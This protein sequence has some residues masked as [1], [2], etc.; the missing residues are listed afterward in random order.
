MKKT[1]I[2]AA[3]LLAAI[4]LVFSA[5]KQPSDD[6]GDDS[7]DDTTANVISADI[8]AN[9]T[10]AT[11]VWTVTSTFTVSADLIIPAGTT[12]N[13]Q[14][15]TAMIVDTNGSVTASGTSGE[16]VVF[17]SAKTTKAAG[18]WNG[19]QV[20]S[21]SASFT[22]C[23]FSYADTALDLR[24]SANTVNS[25]TFSHNT[26]GL[27][28]SALAA[29][30]TVVGNTF[31][32]NG[33]P[34]LVNGK[35]N[36]GDTNSFADNTSQRI[37]FDGSDIPA[38]TSTYT[39]A[40][41]EVPF[42]VNGTFTVNAPL[43]INPGVTLAFAAGQQLI[44]DANASIA[45]NGTDL[46]PITFTSAKTTKA[47]GDWAG[48][49]VFANS[50]SF[51]HCTVSYAATGI[52]FRGTNNAVDYCTFSHNT[53]GL[54][55]TALSAT[56]GVTNTAFS[57]NVEPLLVNGL[58][59]LGAT[60]TFTG[61][62]NQRIYVEGSDIP[63]GTATVW[64]ET[65]VPFYV[66]ATFTAYDSLTVDAG[67]TVAFASGQQLIIDSTASLA[68]AGTSAAPV[69]FTSALTTKAAG[70]WSGLQIWGT[71]TIDWGVFSY[72]DTALDLRNDAF[73]LTNSTISYDNLGIDNYA[74]TW[75]DT[76]GTNTYSNNGT[77][78]DPNL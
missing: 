16:P 29:D 39:W 42:Y 4:L 53:N 34:L 40:E 58:N 1:A 47:A 13:F 65:G 30:A 76:T 18:D 45:A 78:I 77:D 57:A 51:S 2:A 17:T 70:D 43:V 12:L 49:Q 6:S 26:N 25:C 7:G 73:E 41:T 44:V 22:Y 67:V 38:G 15:N 60:N 66:N 35:I 23:T 33:E 24:G 64:A 63:A 61:N 75:T 72:A 37:F 5:C 21:N 68:V 3:S 54:D 20:F 36:L 10:L 11:G 46:A 52:D 32:G 69:T 59:N 62:T 9:T 27:D 14:A 74:S 71:A 19:I 31:S 48:I 28:I 56:V 55:M 50:A 8:T